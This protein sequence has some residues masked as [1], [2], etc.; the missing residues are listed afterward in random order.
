MTYILVKYKLTLIFP[1]SS[2]YCEIKKKH[3]LL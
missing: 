2:E 3:I 1:N